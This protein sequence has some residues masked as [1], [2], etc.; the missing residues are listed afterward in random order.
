[1]KRIIIHAMKITLLSIFPS[2]FDS[3]L[4]FPVIRRAIKNNLVEIEVVDIREYTE[5]SY[6]A[7]DDSP[8]GGGRGLILRTDAMMNALSKVK[9]EN[10]RT[11]LMGPKGRKFN[12]ALAREY[13]KE[14]HIILIA[15]HYEGVDERFRAYID[16]EVSIGDYILT[17]GESAAAIVAEATI[18]LLEGALREE[19]ADIESFEENL[20]EFPQY[21]HPETYD[22]VKVPDVLLKGNKDQIA[23]YQE[24][25]AIRDT[26]ELRPDLLP[27]DQEFKY[28]SL[29][30]NYGNEKEVL[31]LLKDR[32]PVPEIVH[33]NDEYLLLTKLKGKSLGNASKNKIIRTVSSVLRR[34][35]SVDIKS[36][37]MREDRDMTLQ[38]LK[39]EKLSYEEWETLKELESTRPEDDNVFSHG[40]LKL[41]NILANGSG[42]TGVINFQRAGIADRYRDLASIIDELEEIGIKPEELTSLLIIY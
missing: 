4:T 6:R 25:E 23:I 31:H 9:T 42:L 24:R 12:Q 35:W 10:S 13:S 26:I 33:S 20:L 1:M 11:I 14:E 19:S 22:G 17:G 40:N 27:S 41:D 37:N 28:F 16:E 2:S 3:F 36:C 39:N 8:Y 5:G 34:L 32:L 21:T 38:R 30:R 15:G 7:I 18:R 29:H